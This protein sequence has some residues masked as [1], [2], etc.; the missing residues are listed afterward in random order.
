[1]IPGIGNVTYV[2][3]I[4]PFARKVVGKTMPY[5]FPIG[6]LIKVGITIN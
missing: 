3:T 4:F 2:D 1:M 5:L 6:R